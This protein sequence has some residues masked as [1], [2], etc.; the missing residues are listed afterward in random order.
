ML[1]GMATFLLQPL[2]APPLIEVIGTLVPMMMSGV[3]IDLDTTDVAELIPALSKFFGK[4]NKKDLETITRDLLNGATCDGVQLF[5]DDGKGDPF[6]AIMMGRTIDTW[7]L[8]FRS[9]QVN[10]PDFFGLFGAKEKS[11]AAEEKAAPSSSA[12]SNT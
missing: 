9:M 4:L 10:Y 11:P 5:R 7:K 1:T 3:P 6:N 8:L 2:I 12:T